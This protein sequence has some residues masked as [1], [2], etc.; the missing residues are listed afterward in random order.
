MSSAVL[1][2]VVAVVAGAVSAV[3][4]IAMRPYKRTN[5]QDVSDDQD[6]D[7]RDRCREQRK[8]RAGISVEISALARRLDGTADGARVMPNNGAV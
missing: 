6:D 7:G 2:V 3:T 5:Q 4:D 8:L 1:V